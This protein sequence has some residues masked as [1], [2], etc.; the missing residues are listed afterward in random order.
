MHRYAYLG[1]SH[2]MPPRLHSVVVVRVIAMFSSCLQPDAGA[3][4]DEIHVLAL[5][6]SQRSVRTS[7]LQSDAVFCRHLVIWV[8]GSS[9]DAP[10]SSNPPKACQP[11]QLEHRLSRRKTLPCL[12]FP[13]LDFCCDSIGPLTTSQSWWSLC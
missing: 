2:P 11:N 6:L 10:G 1:E 8:G 4:G 12:N 9:E 13:R 3:Q 5:L 7:G